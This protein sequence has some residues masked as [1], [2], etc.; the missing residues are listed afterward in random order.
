[1]LDSGEE[2]FFD[3]L[4]LA[5]GASPRLL[6][7]PG[8]ELPNIYYV[9]TLA[10]VDRLQHAIDVARANGR[11]HSRGRGKAV[12]VGDGV[13][14]IELAASLTQL[15]LSVELIAAH[16]WPWHKFAGEVT[17]KWLLR[18]LENHGITV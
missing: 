10:D 11:R 2:V 18:Y 4:L 6:K 1:T 17:G 5:T 14:G 9:R 15:D 8:A 12:V 16:D 13:L 3:R 7:I